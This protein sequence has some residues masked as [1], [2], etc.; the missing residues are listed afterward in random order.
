MM[1]K[2]AYGKNDLILCV[3]Y[4]VVLVASVSAVS[5]ND[6]EYLVRGN[7]SLVLDLSLIDASNQDSIRSSLAR[8]EKQRIL[9]FTYALDH[10]NRVTL[11]FP[12]SG[13]R[14]VKMNTKISVELVPDA[15]IVELK[16]PSVI[17]KQEQLNKEID[18]LREKS[19]SMRK[20]SAIRLESE[21]ATKQ[22]E[23]PEILAIHLERIADEQHRALAD[24]TEQLQDTYTT[25]RVIAQ[26]QRFTGN[27][28]AAITGRDIE[29]SDTIQPLESYSMVIN[30]VV[31]ALNGDE[32]ARIARSSYVKRITPD[33]SFNILLSDSAPLIGASQAWDML[34]TEGMNITGVGTSIAIIDT[35]VDYTHPD[36]GACT[37]EQFIARTCMKVVDGYD[38]ASN[39]NDPM[40]SQ[41]HGT[42][43]A[44]TAAGNGRGLILQKEKKQ[45]ETLIAEDILS[46]LSVEGGEESGG[47]GG[48]KTGSDKRVFRGIAPEAT[49][50]AYK[51]FEG[52]G[53]SMSDIISAIERSVDPNQDG[54]TEDHVEVIS[55]S[56]GGY[57]NPDDPLSIA[58]DRATAVG[59]VVVV[60]AGNDGPSAESVGSPGTAREVI[61][62]GASYKKDYDHKLWEDESPR[63]DQ[64]T[65]FSS[66]GPVIWNGNLIPKLNVVVPGA[67]IW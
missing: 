46:E 57:G 50:Y 30:G 37:T 47:G 53:A 26:L 52:E 12:D 22:A 41:G 34:D 6:A 21:I 20:S 15:Y 42:H 13:I 10:P 62:V 29:T 44:A 45:E 36:L 64:V 38:F 17:E 18:D 33:R 28:A 9:T 67:L 51:V 55:M 43:V 2:R 11:Q 65:S 25:S 27:V 8:L 58:S 35:G 48:G 1:V 31:L 16:T 14:R 59:A 66:R 39:D 49:I 3:F 19:K 40:D 63:V 23:Q 54:N 61:T 7:E 60:A 5:V 4:A 32:A 24:I 56:L